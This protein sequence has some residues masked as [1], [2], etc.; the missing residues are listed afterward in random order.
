MKGR[1]QRLKP[2]GLLRGELLHDLGDG[3]ADAEVQGLCQARTE[4]GEL[5]LRGGVGLEEVAVDEAKLLLPL[6]LH[7]KHGVH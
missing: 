2:R 3:V 7:V 6:A 4:L 5:C 1:F